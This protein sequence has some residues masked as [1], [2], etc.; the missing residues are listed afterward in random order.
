MLLALIIIWRSKELIYDFFQLSLEMRTN[1]TKLSARSSKDNWK[2]LKNCILNVYNNIIRLP[3]S[4][5][6]RIGKILIW[7]DELD[8]GQKISIF[9]CY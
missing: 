8:D 1:P 7:F 3:R 6:D 2:S 5:V 4:S 9:I